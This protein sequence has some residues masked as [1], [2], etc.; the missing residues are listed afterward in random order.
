MD[1][2]NDVKVQGIK[3][4]DGENAR[5]SAQGLGIEVEQHSRLISWNTDMLCQPLKKI[6]AQQNPRQKSLSR[7]G[8]A[9]QIFRGASVSKFGGSTVL[10]ELSDAIAFD[11]VP[12]GN[13]DPSKV[14]LNP[15]VLE[16]LQSYVGSIAVMHNDE[17]NGNYFHNFDHSSHLSLNCQKVS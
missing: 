15:K 13:V 17:S 6:A 7:I 9:A 10:E 16:Q 12:A 3:E 8:S 11:D 4:F 1:K 5:R 14:V 2:S